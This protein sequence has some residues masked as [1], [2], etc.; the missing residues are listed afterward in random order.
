MSS[1]INGSGYSQPIL[2]AQNIDYGT[3][4]PVIP[5]KEERNVRAISDLANKDG[6]LAMMLDKQSLRTDTTQAAAAL[7]KR[8]NSN[9]APDA[10]AKMGK[11]SVANEEGANKERVLDKQSLPTDATSLKRKNNDTD[12]D[13][14]AKKVKVSVP[15]PGD[16]N[17]AGQ[18]NGAV[19][20]LMNTQLNITQ[21]NNKSA[22]NAKSTSDAAV[23]GVSSSGNQVR[24][25]AAVAGGT[26]ITAA[27]ATRPGFVNTIGALNQV[28][29]SN[30]IATVLL[31][32]ERNAHQAA[33]QATQRGVAA[34]ELAGDKMIA[35]AEEN[36]K[37]AI[38]SGSMAIAG[39]GASAGM[40][41]K[42]LKAEGGSIKTNLKPAR[43]LECGVQNHQNDIKAAKDTLVHQ[44]E[45]VSSETK[46]TIGL[47]NADDM[48]KIGAYRD[49]HNKITLATQKT[50]VGA[51]YANQGINAA[52]GA[53][54]S[55]FGV[56]AAELQKEAELARA[57]R[58]VNSELA[59]TQNQTASKAGEARTAI[60]NALDNQ[61]NANNSA[62]SS[63]AEKT[64]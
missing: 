15:N 8:E 13:R 19:A 17:K 29:V 1:P 34:A 4:D 36:F 58:E 9:I 20:A 16:A 62:V 35:A 43:N 6:V 42:A 22:E 47:S 39:Q 10:P 3:K 59:S 49:N 38:V 50:R 27:E 61:M 57:E 12:M 28:E 5:Q 31:D 63:M 52:K 30:I 7:L 60:Q 46:A 21:P 56:N 18:L 26:D 51:D 54:E 24:S 64:R 41:M 2:P 55:A 25:Q 37:G 40:Q 11:F 23:S 44:G 45:K 14:P 53:A 33:A 48:S 32:A